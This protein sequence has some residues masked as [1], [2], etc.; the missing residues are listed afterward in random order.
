M[1]PHEA[2]EQRTLPAHVEGPLQWIVLWFAVAVTVEAHEEVPPHAMSQVPASQVMAPEQEC[3]P[4]AT[5][6]D[7]PPQETSPQDPAPEQSMMHALAALQSTLAPALGGTVTEQ[8]IPAGHVS[9][10]QPPE[11]A[12]RQTPPSQVPA[13]PQS[14][15]HRSTAASA[16]ASPPASDMTAPASTSAAASVAPS[17]A[18]D[19]ESGNAASVAAPSFA[20]CSV[21][22]VAPSAGT[23][24]S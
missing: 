21:P 23:G 11:H 12:R 6:H 15:V 14:A 2:P 13:L 5:E 10:V 19:A 24:P 7:E 17:P 18:S 8:G 9:W 4:H 1:M 3:A 22:S 16:P 20:S